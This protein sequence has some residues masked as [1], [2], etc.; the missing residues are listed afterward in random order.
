M[1][2]CDQ[3][4]GTGGDGDPLL[5]CLERGFTWEDIGIQILKITEFIIAVVSQRVSFLV[6]ALDFS[7]M[8]NLWNLL[9]GISIT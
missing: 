5:I 2:E 6:G 7:V 9:T 3:L 4:T 1:H 8:Q